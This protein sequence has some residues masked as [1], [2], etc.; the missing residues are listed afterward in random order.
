V[1]VGVVISAQ[2]S[3]GVATAGIQASLT[4]VYSQAQ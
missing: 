1:Q 2:G 3:I 4:L